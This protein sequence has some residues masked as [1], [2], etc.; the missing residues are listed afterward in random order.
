MPKEK[1]WYVK[2][3]TYQYNEDV[4]ALAKKQGLIIIDA[5]FDDG[6]GETDVPKLT[7]KGEHGTIEENEPNFDELVKNLPS[8]KAKELEA[9]T[10]HLGIEYTNADETRAAISEK[11]AQE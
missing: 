11:L 1:I 7:K 9:L 5:R 6:K 10:E 8:L 4:K 2:F 3:P